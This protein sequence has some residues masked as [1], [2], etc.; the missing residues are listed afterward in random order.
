MYHAWGHISSYISLSRR[1]SS[2]DCWKFAFVW[3]L[4]K[5]CWQDSVL[6]KHLCAEKSSRWIW[7]EKHKWQIAIKRP[8]TNH[9][10]LWK[11]R[12]QIT[13]SFNFKDNPVNICVDSTSGT[14]MSSRSTFDE[15]TN[16]I[17]KDT[18]NNITKRQSNCES[19]LYWHQKLLCGIFR[20][21][22]LLLFLVCHRIVPKSSEQKRIYRIRVSF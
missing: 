8:D 1:M 2:I 20:S 5:A 22:P 18:I 21:R 19:S 12:R 3:L 7:S 6:L 14:L 11:D 15:E 17:S 4:S 9:K 16:Y 13:D 10:L